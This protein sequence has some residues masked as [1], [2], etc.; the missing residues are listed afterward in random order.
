MELYDKHFRCMEVNPGD[1]EKK[2]R[3]LNFFLNLFDFFYD[4][5]LRKA[6]QLPSNDQQLTDKK[7]VH[8]VSKI[9]SVS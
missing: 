4:I 6:I 5:Q 7:T 2:R 1:S 3:T 9:V 8:Q